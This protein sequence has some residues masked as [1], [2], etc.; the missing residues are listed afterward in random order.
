M[1]TRLLIPLLAGL[2]LWPAPVQAQVA[3]DAFSAED[4]PGVGAPSWTH[5]PVGTPRCV[6]VFIPQDGTTDEISGVTYGGTAMTEMTGSPN[7]LTTGEGGGVHGFFLGA[8]VPTG[9]QTVAATGDAGAIK[10][11]YAITLTAAADCELVDTD[12]TIQSASQAD[13]TV[14]LSLSGRTSFAAIG[15]Y[16]GQ[17][18][19]TSTTPFTDWNSRGEGSNTTESV[20]S[21]TYD[22]VSTTDVSAGW[23]QTANDAVM[24]A[25]AVSEVAAGGTACR[26]SLLGVGCD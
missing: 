15:G 8:S 19:S 6:I 11:G 13:P 26:M 16:S 21:Y 25:V 23:T 4:A 2:L 14:T 24:I 1:T 9:A 20:L 17:N 12:A 18:A 3:F 10:W 5:T 22:I 7:L